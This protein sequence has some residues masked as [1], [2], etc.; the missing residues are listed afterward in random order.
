MN[1]LDEPHR[2]QEDK[3][4]LNEFFYIANSISDISQQ[5]ANISNEISEKMYLLNNAQIA[6]LQAQINPYFLFNMLLLSSLSI[7]RE[8]K[9]DNMAIYLI[10]QLSSLVR[11]AYDTEN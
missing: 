2:L 10:H 9:R 1:T 7:I 5:N 4:L 11:T 6:A 3:G 8:I